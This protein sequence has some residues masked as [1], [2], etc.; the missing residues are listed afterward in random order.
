MHGA[1]AET[2]YFFQ[3]VVTRDAAY[4]LMLP[5]E[6]NGFHVAA[7]EAMEA[8]FTPAGQ[9][10]ARAAEI[11][12][13]FRVASRSI[14]GLAARE[15]RFVN[16]AGTEAER[17]YANADALAHWLRLAEIGDV[18]TR[19]VGVHRA[20]CIAMLMGDISQAEKLLA[21]ALQQARE[22][23]DRQHEA[24][25]L[26]EFANLYWH[27]SRDEQSIESCREAMRLA[28]EIGDEP[29]RGKTTGTLAIMLSRRVRDLRL[30]DA[31][32]VE[33]LFNEALAIAS[34]SGDVY[35]HAMSMAAYG[36]LYIW[37]DNTKARQCY[38]S[39]LE[40][41]GKGN[42]PRV[43]ALVLSNLGVIAVEEGRREDAEQLYTRAIEINRRCGV[44]H[45]LSITLGNL[46]NLCK[47]AGRHTE[48]EHYYVEGLRIARNIGDAR[49][50]YSKL[51]NYVNL[52]CDIGRASDA[53]ALTQDFMAHRM[54]ADAALNG[55]CLCD[56][57][58]IHAA[59]GHEAEARQFWQQGLELAADGVRPQEF[60]NRR[61]QVRRSCEAAGIGQFT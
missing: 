12:H 17:N 32:E 36:T 2:E 3:H 61:K 56:L 57:A 9:V 4:Q 6:R 40:I 60:D 16:I 49:S 59:L 53:L 34:T 13:H 27:T 24:M 23:G 51:E 22:L 29:L 28:T 1:S 38:E 26:G 47:E 41:A 21:Q 11:A 43:E 31:T 15:A 52:L 30:T 20:G 58:R 44:Q 35:F 45:A 8:L 46:A 55:L 5:T 54:P 10:A 48:A 25:A 37:R 33:G 42:E 50:E 7:A 39:A 19:L 14:A 18:A